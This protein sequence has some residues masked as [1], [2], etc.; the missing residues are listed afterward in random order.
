MRTRYGVSP[1]LEEAP[2]SRRIDLPR[3]RGDRTAEV[4]IIGGGLTGC[5]I[6]YASS[7]AG[8]ETL[9][10]E[11]DR[12]GLGSTGRSAGLL[13]PEPGPSFRDVAAAHGLRAARRVFETW[14]RGAFDGAAL[15]K[16]LNIRCDLDPKVLTVTAGREDEASLRREFEARR[17][18]GLDVS[19]LTPKQLTAGLRLHA[20]G[21]YRLK[22]SFSLDPYRACVGLASAANRRGAVLCERSPVRKVRFTRKYADVIAE[23]GTIRT[24]RV[25]VATGSASAEF[26]SL[27]RHFKPREMYA[28]MTEAVPP[29]IRKELGDRGTVLGDFRTPPWHV[30]WTPDSRLVVAGADQDETTGKKRDTTLVQRTGQLMYELLTKYPAISGLQPQYGWEA[31]YGETADGLMYIGAHRNFPHHMFALGHRGDSVTGAFVAARMVTRAMQDATDKADD[32][33]G[34]NR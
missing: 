31:P 8:F 17:S 23:G 6:A 26:K 24:T 21:G 1:W 7:A 4:V 22:G 27:Q 10:L 12:I 15:I 34:W 29:A 30:R 2:A 32:V 14:R 5:A 18:A 25:I 16:R 13:T 33:F 9:L 11:R 19:W 3:F 20:A 28:V